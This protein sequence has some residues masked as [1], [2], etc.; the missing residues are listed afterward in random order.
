MKSLRVLKAAAIV[1]IAVVL[2]LLTAQGSFAVWNAATASGAGTIQSANFSILVNG[3]EMTSPGQVI[4][5]AIGTLNPGTSS[6]TSIQVT[7]N[8]NATSGSKVRPVITAQAAANGLAPYVSVQSG[9][10]PAGQACNSTWGAPDPL[11]SIDQN[12]TKTVCVKVTL[13]Q[14]IPASLLGTA[15]AVPVTLTVTQV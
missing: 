8:T 12:V 7:N 14:N 10:L 2:G 13:A 6:Y 9:T 15:I 3:A 11:Q 4:F 1:A 5:P